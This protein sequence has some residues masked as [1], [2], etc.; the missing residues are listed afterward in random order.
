MDIDRKHARYVIVYDPGPVP[1]IQGLSLNKY[2][3]FLGLRLGAFEV[4][5]LIFNTLQRS[6]HRVIQGK[7]KLTMLPPME[8]KI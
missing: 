7:H 5:T 2:E 8:Q 6:L 3:M 4:N 1:L